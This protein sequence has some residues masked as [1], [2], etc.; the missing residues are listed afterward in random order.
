MRRN[1]LFLIK[2]TIDM[3][4]DPWNAIV[5][6]EKSKIRVSENDFI[7]ELFLHH[8]LNVAPGGHIDK[9]HVKMD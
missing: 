9:T 3:L 5:V 4:C 6:K 7:L 8:L 2:S 1:V